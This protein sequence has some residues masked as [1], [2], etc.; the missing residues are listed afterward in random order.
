MARTTGDR[1][2]QLS[3]PH[4][5]A[6]AGCAPIWTGAVAV[7]Q[8]DQAPVSVSRQARP[9]GWLACRADL[10]D[11]R[12]C[13]RTPIRSL[14]SVGPARFLRPGVGAQSRQRKI[15]I[16]GDMAPGA[17]GQRPVDLA[18]G[19]QPRAACVAHYWRRSR[20]P[21]AA[22]STSARVRRLFAEPKRARERADIFVSGAARK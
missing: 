6:G 16:N 9:V 5:L 17:S 3:P 15:N 7:D 19:V 10:I 18:G 21:L 8:R 4:H 11:G 13:M 20:R 22:K 12:A 1:G 2:R 14:T